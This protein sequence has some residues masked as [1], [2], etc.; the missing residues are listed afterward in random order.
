[1]S[2]FG[3]RSTAEEVSAGVDLLGRNAIVTGANTGIGLETTRA[4]ALRG[5]RVVMACRNL[6]KA[7]TARQQILHQSADGIAPDALEIMQLDLASLASVRT[8]ARQIL[9]AGRPL[10]LLINNAGIMIPDR[11]LTEDGFE[12][13]FGVNH[14]GHF[15]LTTLLLDALEAGAPARVVNVSSAAQQMAA[16]T[17]ELEDLNWERRSW[18]GWRAYGSSKLMNCLFTN[19][20]QRRMGGSG[21]VSNA[22]HPG[23]V[24]TEL[25]RDQTW[26][27]KIVGLLML[28]AMKNAAQGAATSVLLATA[29]EYASE[30]GGYYA[31]CRPARP[32]R[33]AGDPD[34]QRR[35]WALS[36]E[37]TAP[38][39]P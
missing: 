13:Q 33:L 36:E 29:S 34:T 39:G 38:A 7:E 35:L 18:S 19:E 9:D 5:A 12:A 24:A 14:L 21:V 23:I 25:A 4:L 27:M 37:L 22:L 11:R 6:E 16:L 17:E 31:D 32:A 1:M 20:L 10:Q 15:L 30:G 2:G 3:R 8:F 28:P 26:G